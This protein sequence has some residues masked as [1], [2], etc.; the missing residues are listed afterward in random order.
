MTKREYNANTDPNKKPKLD[1]LNYRTYA[2][3]WLFYKQKVKIDDD[4]DDNI[5]ITNKNL[6]IR[7]A[8]NL[9]GSNYE[10][11]LYKNEV[12]YT[13]GDIRNLLKNF[14]GKNTT[15][16]TFSYSEVL[17]QYK[18]T[19]E[20]L[21]LGKNTY[22]NLIHRLSV[23][24]K[25]GYC[26][27][28][29]KAKYLQKFNL[30]LGDIYDYSILSDCV[31]LFS[32]E[33][34]KLSTHVHYI[35]KI[36]IT[37][38]LKNED[39]SN[40]GFTELSKLIYRFFNDP[41]SITDMKKVKTSIKHNNP[42]FLHLKDELFTEYEIPFYFNES[43]FECSWTKNMVTRQ[44]KLQ[45]IDFDENE[46]EVTLSKMLNFIFEKGSSI[47]DDGRTPTFTTIPLLRLYQ[48]PQ[49]ISKLKIKR[50]NDYYSINIIQEDFE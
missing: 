43:P 30:K 33:T 19:N 37:Y 17:N 42:F 36:T 38:S 1:E 20:P 41:L 5:F 21:I 44:L 2:V 3:D 40:F 23:I 7:Y 28:G 29:F 10:N 11:I 18:N 9:D 47:I 24:H 4:L 32:P 48:T 13:L 34:I 31:Q 27:I 25:D 16:N 14:Y 6:I 12:Q 26:G 45:R 46:S 15:E 8:K 22:P 49:K 39:K 35:N 50:K